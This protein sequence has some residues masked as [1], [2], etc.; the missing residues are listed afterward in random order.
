MDL[1]NLAVAEGQVLI[2]VLLIALVPMVVMFV[3]SRDVMALDTYLTIAGVLFVV[4]N[5][6]FAIFKIRDDGTIELAVALEESFN[7]GESD[8]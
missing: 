8:E 7:Q 1:K 4:A 6:V 2:R 3:A 5:L